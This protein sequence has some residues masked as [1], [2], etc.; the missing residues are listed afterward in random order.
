MFIKPI[1]K[2]VILGVSLSL[3]F[4]ASANEELAKKNNCLACHTVD[5][6]ILGPAYKDVAAKYENNPENVTMLVEKVKKGGSGNWGQ[7]PMPPNP[8]V[9]DADAKTLVEWVL[10]Q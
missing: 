6:K 5:K 4:M 9:S 10:S 3:P 7:M 8:M 2:A 1:T